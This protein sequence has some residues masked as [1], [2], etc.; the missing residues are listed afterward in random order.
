NGQI[1]FTYPDRPSEE[2][3]T[4]LPMTLHPNPSRILIVGG[5]LGTLKEFLKYPISR[6]DFLELDRKLIDVSMR[7]INMKED[8]DAL[9]D[10]RVDIIVE[11]GRRFIK[12]LKRQEYDLI[13]LNLPPPVTASINR[14]YTTDFFKEVRIVLNND[15][16]LSITLPQSAGYIGRSMQ[17]AN[18]SI[19][20]SLKSVFRHVEVTTQEY[21]GF[22]ASDGFINT[23][24]EKLE[25]RFVNRRIH[26]R[27]FSQFLFYD[28]FSKFGTDYVKKRLAE[29]YLINKDLRPSSYLYNLILW[30]EVHG[31]KAL[32][33]LIKLRE[34]HFISLL[35]SITIIVTPLIFRQRNRVISFCIFTT[36]FSGMALIIAVLLAYQSIYGYVYEKIG[37]LSATFMIGLWT[38]S[39]ILRP[40][41]KLL[42]NIF[43]LEILSVGLAFVSSIFFK[44]EILFYVLNFLLGI[45]A[46]REFNLANIFWDETGVAGRLYGLDLTGAVLGAFIPAIILIPLFGIKN[47]LFIVAGIKAVSA[48][49][50]LSLV[51]GKT[52]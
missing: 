41:K 15:G 20:N 48:V 51:T 9:R 30:S 1:F 3:K 32:R 6:I 33:Y 40:P 46:G 25:K 28:I 19:Y 21:S 26:T 27:H 29:I 35:L 4:H 52:T 17:T 47:T 39:H 8:K 45:I 10:S 7:L 49:M 31:G 50:V 12:R 44:I 37:I 5:S 22:F 18:G 13:I 2:L 42:R 11:D 36:G 24:A 23:D 38:G 16:I 14:F 34:W 43:F